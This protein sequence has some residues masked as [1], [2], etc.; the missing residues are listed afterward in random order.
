MSA[1]S[2]QSYVHIPTAIV[3]FLEKQDIWIQKLL[4]VQHNL[5]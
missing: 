3:L 4:G 2:T 1:Y 5:L